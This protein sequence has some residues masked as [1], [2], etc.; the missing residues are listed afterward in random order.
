M[1]SLG[2]VEIDALAL[3]LRMFQCD[4][5]AKTPKHAGPGNAR[6]EGRG[7]RRSVLRSARDQREARQHGQA[8]GCQR[9]RDV[10]RAAA[11]TFLDRVDRS[12]G[13]IRRKRLVEAPEMNDASTR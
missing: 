5:P 6:R 2:L 4:R 11:G 10:E 9:L 3:K 1:F 12:R 7:G 8:R 13:E